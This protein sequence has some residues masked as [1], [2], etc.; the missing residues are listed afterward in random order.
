[1]LQHVVAFV[2]ARLVADCRVGIAAR[3][4]HTAYIDW[5]DETG[6]PRL[7]LTRFGLLMPKTGIRRVTGRTVTY[8]ARFK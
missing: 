8:E 1:M 7:S 4:L 2:D 3:Q 6:A 5:A